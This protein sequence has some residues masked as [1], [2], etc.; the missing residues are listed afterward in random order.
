MKKQAIEQTLQLADVAPVITVGEDNSVFANLAASLAEIRKL[1]GV[2]GYI[3][4]G[5]NSAVVDLTEQ[6]II[7]EYALLSLQ[8]NLAS[9]E[10][11]K[12]FNLADVESVLVAGKNVKVL[13]MSLGGN[14]ISVFMEKTAVHAWIIKRILL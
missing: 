4:R 1:K 7:S 12:H 8:I 9:H 3:L 11:T 2:T 5:E 10:M 13:C 6:N 14:K